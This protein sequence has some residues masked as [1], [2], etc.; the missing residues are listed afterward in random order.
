MTQLLSFESVLLTSSL[1]A[2]EFSDNC[3][4]ARG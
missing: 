3:L 1:A 2:T 4:R